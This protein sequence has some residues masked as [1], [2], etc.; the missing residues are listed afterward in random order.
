MPIETPMKIAKIISLF[1]V[2]ASVVGCSSSDTSADDAKVNSDVKTGGTP[3]GMESSTPA[4]GGGGG[5][6]AGQASQA[7]TA[8]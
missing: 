8:P 2:I 1:V 7:A 5:A 6:A 3:P 4:G